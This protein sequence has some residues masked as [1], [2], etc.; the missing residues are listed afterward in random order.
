MYRRD[1]SRPVRAALT[2]AT[3]LV[4][5]V[6][7]ASGPET[8]NAREEATSP[9][10]AA[11]RAAGG[12]ESAAT[13]GDLRRQARGLTS[14]QEAER[15]LCEAGEEGS[16]NQ[17]RDAYR[18]RCVRT[19]LL[20]FGADGGVEDRIREVDAAVKD[21]VRKRTGDAP[22]T[23][24]PTET[25]EAALRFYARGGEGSAPTL[26]YRWSVGGGAQNAFTA[27]VD[28]EDA[29]KDKHGFTLSDPENRLCDTSGVGSRAQRT[30]VQKCRTVDQKAEV[31][32]I[33]ERH[34]QVFRVT[35]EDTYYELGW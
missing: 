25:A 2:A 12:K 16:F 18:F 1:L 13:A 30:A 6:G 20:Y 23:D 8:T 3:A 9:A 33:R 24:L 34:R 32:K 4:L 26:T 27:R 7:C 35:L 11:A 21:V 17:G 10:A 31:A 29:L 19:L 28:W 14:Y 15:D 5:C 22:R